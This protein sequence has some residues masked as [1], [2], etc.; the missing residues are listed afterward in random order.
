M[1]LV[2]ILDYMAHPWLNILY[3]RDEIMRITSLQRIR[4]LLA[5]M[6]FIV[7]LSAQAA[8]TDDAGLKFW[9]MRLEYSEDDDKGG[10]VLNVMNNTKERFLIKASISA[11]DPE[12]GRFG[13]TPTSVP[14][15]ILPPLTPVSAGEQRSFRI[16]QIGASALRQ[17]RESAW[18]VSA[19]AIPGVQGKE[20]KDISGQAA[21][22]EKSGVQIA[23]QMNMR[24]FF[25]PAG[26][27]P[28]DN[29]DIAGKLAFTGQKNNLRVN[30]PTPYF[31]R[32]NQL[33]VNGVALKDDV[34]QGYISPKSQKTFVLNSPATG[35]VSWI[36]PGEVQVRKNSVAIID[37]IYR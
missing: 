7:S 31:V 23:L 32:L 3:K 34:N 25:R 15:F 35:N 13:V 10:V 28:R 14:F 8:S 20:N 21:K 22:E 6:N 17:D 26:L 30:N 5:I 29:N 37:G 1:I 18:I 19:T 36:F 27:P 11:M 4:L 24:L 16:R 9:P 12:T 33:A 2:V